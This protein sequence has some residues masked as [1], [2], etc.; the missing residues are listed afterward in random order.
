V[1]SSGPGDFEY[2]VA[3]SYAR[4]QRSY[5]EAVADELLRQGVRVFYDGYEQATLWGKNLYEHLN[6]VYQ[7]AA[8]YCV[9]FA[10]QEY[11]LKNWTNHELRGAQAR[12]LKETD[13]E[14]ILPARFDDT[15]I[16]G[17]LDTIAYID[18]TRKSPNE[19]ANLIAAKLRVHDPSSILP[20]FT[21]EA[22]QSYR[23]K[24]RRCLDVFGRMLRGAEF[25]GTSFP[26]LEIDLSLLGRENGCVLNDS[27]SILA[28]LSS[29]MSGSGVSGGTIVIKTAGD[30][31]S[32]LDLE[33]QT[34]LGVDRV[35]TTARSLNALTV[36]IG[37]P[38]T[39]TADDLTAASLSKD[40]H[41]RLLNRELRRVR[42]G[43]DFVLHIDG[44][45]S[46]QMQLDSIA[47]FGAGKGL[48]ILLPLD[49]ERFSAY[50]NAAQAISGVQVAVGAN[51]PFLC[52]KE[53]WRETRA[54][55]LEQSTE[56]SR[57]ELRLQGV[58]PQVW[59]GE[60][61]INSSFDLFE[62][63]TRYFPA[64]LPMVDDE[65]PVEVLKAG[66]V[67][68][69]SELVLQN[70]TIYRW[71]RPIYDVVRGVPRLQM[72]NRVLAAGPTV[73]DMIADSAFYFGLVNLLANAERALWSQLSFSAAEENFHSGVRH[74]LDAEVYWPGLGRVPAAELVLR[75]LLP[76]AHEG[77]EAWGVGQDTRDRLLGIVEGRCLNGC[78]GA[79]WQSQMFHKLYDSGQVDRRDAMRMMVQRY[80]RYMHTNEPVH[81]WPLE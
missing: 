59:F 46:M 50:W 45:E 20:V 72:E 35:S 75:R 64:L 61:W 38:P 1:T 77:L 69:L 27:E 49:P 6:N 40:M 58:R 13:Q 66:G 30:A 51:S 7:D 5:V 37:I 53:L 44:V 56:P 4:E 29:S 80:C 60:R 3:L 14:Y 42:G 21:G 43:E 19:L 48:R 22:R 36:S 9:V 81:T 34:G 28:A 71:N 32:F 39:L 47:G 17:L 73:V 57:F 41:V 23:Q 8:R 31:A 52:G 55:L 65:E 67:P 12:A 11:A 26:G 24:A 15:E 25:S 54:A 68:R 2:D 63:N 70:T 62:E 16:P 78:N 74:G 10:S 33:E 18:L 76:M 79:A